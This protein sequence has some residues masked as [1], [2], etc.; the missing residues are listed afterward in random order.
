LLM[1]FMMIGAGSFAGFCVWL[2]HN[3]IVKPAHP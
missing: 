2:V 1:H 3:A